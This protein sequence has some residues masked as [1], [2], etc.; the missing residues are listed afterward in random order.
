[1]TKRKMKL[2]ISMRYMGYHG[3]SW[4]LPE[5][6]PDGSS[7]FRCFL[8]IVET[9][10]R[11]KLDL[12]FLADGIGIRSDDNPRGSLC[13]SRQNVEL[14]PLTLLSALA[15]LTK[16]IGL[17]ATASTTYNEPY[18]IA[19]KFGSL[20]QISAGRAGWNVVTSW[21]DQEA[22]NFNRAKHLDY[23]TRY[24]RAEEF[25]DVV[26]GLWDSW[27]A[28]AF[29]CDKEAGIFYD[30]RKL[31]VLNHSG[32][33]FTVRGP[34]SVRRSPQGR[35]ILVQAGA[36]E[37]GQQIAARYCDIVFAAKKD[38][39]SAKS[40]YNSVKARLPLYG[41]NRDD[42]LM[43]AGLTPIVAPTRAE[44]RARFERLEGLVDPLVG[45]AMLYR[46]FGDLSHLPL[47]GP[48]PKP[49]LESVGLRSSAQMYWELSQR[50]GL[51]IRQLYKKLGM[52]QEHNTVVGT[53]ADI[54]DEMEAWMD[55]GAA[56][57]FNITPTHLP[58]GLNDFVELV[59][60]EIRRRGLFRDEYEGKTLRENLGLH[61]PASRYQHQTARESQSA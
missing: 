19:R 35:P 56:D 46:S 47:D 25:V 58:H 3:G 16:H 44:A 33:H 34:L 5:V 1:M 52:A 22:W 20:D 49:D 27:D 12:V 61:T 24:E 40:Y 41:R 43:L 26:T 42:L 28:D 59:L 51:T 45:L 17:I 7:D 54:V 18:H 32:K 2:G 9:A 39:G 21:S 37:V 55:G 15:P 36:S 8:D 30:E 38:I 10:E 53:P 29:V 48:V 57:G 13:R 11:N 23:D 60:P 4:R 6:Q 31:H 50:E 14:E